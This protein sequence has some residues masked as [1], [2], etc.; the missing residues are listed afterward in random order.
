[1]PKQLDQDCVMLIINNWVWT[2]VR[3]TL[4]WII[5]ACFFYLI[6]KCDF[7]LLIALLYSYNLMQHR[8][9]DI[10]NRL[11]EGGYQKEFW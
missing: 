11:K 3:W 5:L 8:I 6:Y 9:F 2:G 4:K 10:M 7:F 1:M